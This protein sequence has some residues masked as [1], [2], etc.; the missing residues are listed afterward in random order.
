MLRW[1]CWCNLIRFYTRRPR[2]S[3]FI[4]EPPWWRGKQ[5]PSGAKDHWS[6]LT[7]PSLLTRASTVPVSLSDSVLLTSG[8]YTQSCCQHRRCWSITQIRNTA[9][10]RDSCDKVRPVNN[11]KRKPT[12][13]GPGQG[14]QKRRI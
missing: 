5:K 8:H 11:T 14:L 3:V 1:F 7:H 10:D 6:P 2:H 9:V 4:S 13:M 12:R